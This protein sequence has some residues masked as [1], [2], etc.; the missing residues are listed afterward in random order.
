MNQ[1][2]CT[3]NTYLDTIDFR[4]IQKRKI[5][6][7]IEL[8]VLIIICLLLLIYYVTF[9]YN[10]YISKNISKNL[11][12]SY[13][14]TRIYKTLES[15]TETADDQII[16]YENDSF[17]II[18]IIEIK[19][20]NISYPILSDISKNSLKIAPCRI[21]G[22]MPNEIRKFMHCRTQL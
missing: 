15:N 8:C 4:K 7:H 18:G 14:I 2:I 19:K 20:L 12:D 9:R 6:L 10:L 16:F 5:I 21:Y 22:P 1:I 3:S 11:E 17:K 13:K